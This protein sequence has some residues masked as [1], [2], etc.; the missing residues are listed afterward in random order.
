[1]KTHYE[2]L[3]VAETASADEIKSAYK[4]NVVE[5]HPD[6]NLGDPIAG[7]RTRAVIE[8]NSVLSEP[9]TRAAYDERLRAERDPMAKFRAFREAYKRVHH[10]PPAKPKPMVSYVSPEE[11]LVG[12]FIGLGLRWLFAPEPRRPTRSRTRA[13]YDPRVD[14]VRG[15]D[16]R[17]RSG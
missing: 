2:I 17:F 5:H 13:R 9:L 8:A 16:G 12:K 3:G 7:E 11:E 6:R 14:R 15:P 10:P 4:A 1:M